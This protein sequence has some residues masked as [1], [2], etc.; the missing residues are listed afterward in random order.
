MAIQGPIEPKVLQT[1]LESLSY[2]VTQQ[3]RSN[4]L[5]AVLREGSQD[6][7]N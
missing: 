1:S 3:R 5:T 6:R 4:T 2:A 7:E